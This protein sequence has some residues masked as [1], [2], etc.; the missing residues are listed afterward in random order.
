MSAIVSS[1]LQR[2]AGKPSH[3]HEQRDNITKGH[4][5]VEGG[6]RGHSIGEI[7]PYRVVYLGS[8]DAE[9]WRGGTRVCTYYVLDH[10]YALSPGA[11]AGRQARYYKWAENPDNFLSYRHG[12]A[13][14]GVVAHARSQRFL[15]T[16]ASEP[17]TCGCAVRSRGG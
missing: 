15:E 11:R 8:G 14:P 7:W 9:L 17:P 6:L 1:T 4:S 16:H 3:Y 12:E 2:K 10:P 13:L 5:Q